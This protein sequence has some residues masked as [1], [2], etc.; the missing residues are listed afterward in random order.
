MALSARR[1]IQ[2]VASVISFRINLVAGV[3]SVG[4]FGC[5]LGFGSFQRVVPVRDMSLSPGVLSSP[6][7]VTN[8]AFVT[9]PGYVTIPELSVVWELSSS[10]LGREYDT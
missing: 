3:A 1:A 7:F 5:G 9:S 8:P 4:G 6:G 10:P 2:T